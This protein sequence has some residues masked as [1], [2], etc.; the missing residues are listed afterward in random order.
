MLLKKNSKSVPKSKYTRHFFFPVS[1]I[2]LYSFTEADLKAEDAE[3]K[4]VNLEKELNEQEEK[5]EDL[6]EKHKA[7]KAE[8]DELAR[9]FD[10]F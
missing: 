6:V 3:R 4:I 9:Q 5:Y 7:A 8:M 2:F 1:L 10:D